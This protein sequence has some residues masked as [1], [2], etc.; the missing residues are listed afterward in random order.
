MEMENAMTFTLK[1]GALAVAGGLLMLAPLGADAA[2]KPRVARTI[3]APVTNDVTAPNASLRGDPSVVTD[4]NTPVSYLGRDPDP[5]IRSE[6]LKDD[7]AHNGNA[8]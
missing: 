4:N 8:Y 5:Q 3:P 6:I 7:T 1:A 2:T